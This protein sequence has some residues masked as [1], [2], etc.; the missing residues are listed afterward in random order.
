[1]K[2]LIFLTGYFVFLTASYGQKDN[3]P[4]GVTDSIDKK[5]KEEV[6]LEAMRFSKE[7]SQK[8]YNLDSVAIAFM[9][10]TLRIERYQIKFLAYDYT[11]AGMRQSAYD[12]ADK[13]DS[14]LNKIYK[15]I[16]ALLQPQDKAVL[17]AA[18][19]AWL[20]YRDKELKLIDKISDE[21]YSGGGT[22]WQVLNASDY[23]G[24]VKQRTIEMFSHYL[25]ISG[26]LGK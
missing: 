12:A 6:R 25:N 10:D 23:Y 5:I 20:V 1:M 2:Y 24:M 8:G 14:L 15:K 18:Q 21:K 22:I 17:V 16:L 3:G 26:N 9:V 7:L 4:I 13:Y 19:K 11:T